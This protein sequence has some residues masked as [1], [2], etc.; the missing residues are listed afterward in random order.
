MT[1]IDELSLE[2]SILGIVYDR[3]KAKNFEYPYICTMVHS[4]I[5][6]LYPGADEMET[7][8]FG[9]EMSRRIRGEV[10]EMLDG[11]GSVEGMLYGNELDRYLVEQHEREPVHYCAE[12]LLQDSLAGVSTVAWQYRLAILRVLM[13]RRSAT[14]AK[15]QE[16]HA[17]RHAGYGPG[18]L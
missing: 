2:L 14:I 17:M 6:R 12:D 9:D 4:I 13:A 15:L 16:E 3:V 7:N 18:G 5:A 8:A 10:T 1:T 11:F